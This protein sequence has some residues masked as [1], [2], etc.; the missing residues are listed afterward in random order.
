MVEDT[1]TGNVFV[2]NFGLNTNTS[3]GNIRQYS[4][5]SANGEFTD[6]G[7]YVPEILYAR[8]VSSMFIGK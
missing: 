6:L 3:M 1:S 7:I 8:C 4:V 5:N 2:A